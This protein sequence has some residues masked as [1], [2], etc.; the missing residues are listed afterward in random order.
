MIENP[1]AVFSMFDSRGIE[2]VYNSDEKHK[3]AAS[4][5][6]EGVQALTTWLFSPCTEHPIGHGWFESHRYLCPECMKEL[7]ERVK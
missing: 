6:N 1:H 3:V 7:Q 5:F 4:A 2:I